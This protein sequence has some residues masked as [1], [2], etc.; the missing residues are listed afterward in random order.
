[1]LLALIT[2]AL[3]A[4]WHQGSNQGVGSIKGSSPPFAFYQY[5]L[6][7]FELFG[8]DPSLS[9]L[10]PSSANRPSSPMTF[11]LAPPFCRYLRACAHP[12]A[13]RDRS[14]PSAPRS[15]R[16]SFAASTPRSSS[17]NLVPLPP[18]PGRDPG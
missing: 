1:M 4:H 7:S 11:F 16:L 6:Q 8:E 5:F 12:I 9:L 3:D 10:A 15:P 18:R 14:L 17:H 13:V 2:R